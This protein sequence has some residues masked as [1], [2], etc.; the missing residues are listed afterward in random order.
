MTREDTEA[1]AQAS[2][3]SAAPLT[4]PMQQAGQGMS[5]GAAER[6]CLRFD[7]RHSEKRAPML[8]PSVDGR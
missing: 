1:M 8:I 5:V 4:S 3:L 7:L 2:C 6:R